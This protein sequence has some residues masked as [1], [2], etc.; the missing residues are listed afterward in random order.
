MSA[1]APFV[2]ECKVREAESSLFAYK[3]KSSKK[4]IFFCFL[5]REQGPF[6]FLRS[7][8]ATLEL[9]QYYLLLRFISSYSFACASNSVSARHVS[10]ASTS[11]SLV[12]SP[13]V[14]ARICAFIDSDNWR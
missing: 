5:A 9:S 12:M 2:F 6:I 4:V 3:K 7:Q 14:S 8:F 10:M 11:F 13:F 1:K